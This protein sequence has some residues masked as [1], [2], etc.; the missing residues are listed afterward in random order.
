MAARAKTSPVTVDGIELS[1]TPETFD[2]ID[3]VEAIADCND[4]TSD[5]AAR[6]SAVFRLF[7]AVF[8][9][10]YTRVKRELRAK[11]GGKLTTDQM[12]DF[13]NRVIEAAGAK[14]S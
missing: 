1:V 10:D 2:D 4:P 3:V 13:F 5:D 14:N 9:A 7:R 12:A 8:G 11:N 6:T